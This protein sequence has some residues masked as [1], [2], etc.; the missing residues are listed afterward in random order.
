ML[1]EKMITR[2]PAEDE[3]R[4]KL[5]TLLGKTEMVSALLVLIYSNIRILHSLNLRKTQTFEVARVEEQ[6]TDRFRCFSALFSCH[7]A[8]WIVKIVCSF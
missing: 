3:K 7:S 4:R 1:H 6:R 2:K 5:I 8:P